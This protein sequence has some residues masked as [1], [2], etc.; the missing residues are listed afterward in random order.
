MSC[1]ESFCSEHRLED[2]NSTSSASEKR[3]CP[4]FLDPFIF[5]KHL[6][7]GTFGVVNL[8]RD[9]DSN[10]DCAVKVVKKTH[11]HDD[12]KVRSEIKYGMML[13]SMY[14]CKVLKYYENDENFYIIMEHLEGIDLCDFIR[15]DPKFFVENPRF[16][17]FVVK[18]ILQGLVYLHSQGIAHF[19]IKP[20]NVV[21]L[22]DTNGN[23]TGVK[24]IDL[25][26]A[27]E[28]N[29][30]TKCSGGTASYMA[31][32]IVHLCL[33][34]GFPADIWSFGMTA[35]A[36]LRAYL[37]IRSTHKNPQRANQEIYEKIEKLSMHKT[38]SPFSKRSDCKEIFKIEEF[39]T[40][41]F[42]VNPL[43]RPTA[44]QLLDCILAIER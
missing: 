41:C 11:M 29:E 13:N 34:T 5:V 12:K 21:L 33:A 38:F 43:E 10:L 20:D 3:L 19:D 44:Q 22:L 39:I 27:F 4:N 8:M 23:I 37:P 2:K 9:L 1:N 6:G 30:T 35:Y 14:I 15:N 17:W 36:M 16:F 42:I 24:L 26:Y 25:G 18:S 28:V 32:E 7:S 31:P 40:S